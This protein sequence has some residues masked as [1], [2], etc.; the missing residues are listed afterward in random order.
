[1][2]N[3]DYVY[4]HPHTVWDS[5]K[6]HYEIEIL[7]GNLVAGDKMPSLN[8]IAEDFNISKNTAV[9]VLEQMNNDNLL[10]K[11]R[12]MGYFIKP[13]AKE[14]IYENYETIFEQRLDDIIYFAKTL[15]KDLD[16]I[17]SEIKNKWSV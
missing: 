2:L 13:Y 16:E 9:R 15:N 6:K 14:K 3:K 5:V 1:M 10:F 8:N 7:K 12:G 11:K 17:L 4:K